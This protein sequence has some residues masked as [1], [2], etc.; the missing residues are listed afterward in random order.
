MD[1]ELESVQV[2]ALVVVVTFCSS[3]F[4]CSLYEFCSFV[5]FRLLLISG[6]QL[7]MGSALATSSK[8]LAFSSASAASID[9]RTGSA[10]DQDL[11]GDTCTHI[12]N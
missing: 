5:R 6:R 2:F 4:I 8:T 10:Y 9:R 12:E 3:S 1:A 7:L 11:C